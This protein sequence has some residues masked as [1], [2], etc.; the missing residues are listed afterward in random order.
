MSCE[1]I[2]V[3][4][5]VQEITVCANNPISQ[6][7]P[8]SF[9][10][11]INNQTIFGLLPQVPLA[12]ISLYIMGIGQNPLNSPSDY[13]LDSTGL[14]IVLSEGIPSGQTIFGMYQVT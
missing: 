5:Q 10:A 9:T 7:Q 4:Q 11:I 3:I 6:F 1:P 12:I 14:N 8:F 13:I 2:Q